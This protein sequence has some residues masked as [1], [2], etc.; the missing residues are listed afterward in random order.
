[1]KHSKLQAIC[2][3]KILDATFDD[4]EAGL[5]FHDGTILAIYNKFELENIIPV[6]ASRIIG[7]C[8]RQV[9]ESEASI[10]LIFDNEL[11]LRIDMRGEAFS[12]PE[13]MQLR[14]PGESIVVWN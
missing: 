13:A 9:D 6:D 12:G 7:A 1:M 10:A 2:G 14:V 8:I 3:L 11:T 5:R 4:G